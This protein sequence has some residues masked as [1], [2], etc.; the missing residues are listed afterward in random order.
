[1]SD[2]TA[3]LIIGLA[4]LVSVPISVYAMAF[5]PRRGTLSPGFEK[6][7]RNAIVVGFL[8]CGL[9]S[10]LLQAVTLGPYYAR[11]KSLEAKERR[12]ASEWNRSSGTGD[13][14]NPFSGGS[15]GGPAQQ[16]PRG[17]PFSSGQDVTPRQNPFA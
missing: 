14:G 9:L 11:V 6:Q 5:M 8:P 3:F 7:R 2:S 4:Y 16:P 12:V 17:N 15:S 10:I 13:G 1:M